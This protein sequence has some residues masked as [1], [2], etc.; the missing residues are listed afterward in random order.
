MLGIRVIKESVL[1]NCTTI[2]GKVAITV[3]GLIRSFKS[4]T[5]PAAMV[6]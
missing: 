1:M 4:I 5:E 2:T 3:A 6:L